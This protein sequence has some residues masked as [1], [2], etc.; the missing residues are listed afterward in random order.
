MSIRTQP[1]RRSEGAV[2]YDPF[3][4]PAEKVA[5]DVER[6]LV[7]FD[8]AKRYGVV[9]NKDGSVDNDET[10]NLRKNLSNFFVF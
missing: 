9:L 3:K 2:I 10:E 5:K 6:G 7:S 4:R 1:R 8:G